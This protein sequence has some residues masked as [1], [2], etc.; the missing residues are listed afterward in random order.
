M[1]I[2]K[3]T[4]MTLRLWCLSISVLFF[5]ASALA[6]PFVPA[7]DMAL[8]HDIQRLADYGIIKGTIT[9]WPLAW[10]PILYDIGNVE[11][12]ELPRDIA[13][14]LLRVKQ[15]SNWQTR[16]KELLFNA[17][18]GVAEKPGRIRTFENTPR[19]EAEA[20]VGVSWISDWFSVDLNVQYVD[21][22]LDDEDF[23]ADN[24][25]ISVIAGNWSI[26][27][28]TQQRWWGPSWDGSLIL[29][30]NARPFPSLTIDRVFTDPFKTK[31]LSWLGPWDFSVMMGQLEK[32]RDI[33]NTKFFGM[34]LNFR[35]IQNLEI[36]LSRAAQWCG[37][38]RPCDAGTFKNLLLGRDN[39]GSAGISAENEPGNQLAGVDF[40]WTPKL[41]DSNVGIY[42]QF[43][44]EDEAGG[45]PSRFMG[46]YGVEWSSYLF[47]RW[48]TRAF[49]EYSATI[50]QFHESSKIYN[51]AYRHTIYTSGYRY[52]GL[53][54]GHGADDDAKIL[55]LGVLLLDADN[56]QWRAIFRTGELNSGGFPDSRNSFSPTPQ[57]IV[58]FDVSH[59]RAFQFG[60]IE[61]G[62][63][64]EEIDDA[65]SGTKTS[66]GRAYLQW[67]SSY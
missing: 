50:C 40:R 56:T 66:D 61:V 55:A 31:W 38:D 34:R 1:N 47:D 48:S 36:G 18:L 17:E 25:Q 22:D 16:D 23:R 53:P 51:C 26:A 62:L 9:T 3:T 33:P 28:S 60:V 49:A 43:I 24:S 46:Q 41:F 21:S 44:G 57:D 14:A 15:R 19:G 32:E 52:R 20:S 64:F 2:R 42:G 10:G 65:V 27:A 58:S 6:G 54:I 45:F 11:T 29:S 4:R 63:G 59:K 12:S 37:D 35:P 7:G 8:R 67:R 5:S 39:R 13:D 30:N